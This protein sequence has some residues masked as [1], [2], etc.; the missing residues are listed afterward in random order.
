[1]KEILVTGG[2]GYIGSHFV[3]ALRGKSYHPVIFDNLSTGNRKA[4]ADSELIVGELG[5]KSKLEQ[6]F[7]SRNF[8]AVVHF[9]GSCYVGESVANPRLY[10]EN[11]VMNGWN[12][13]NAMIRS[14]VRNIIF[15]SSCA[16]YGV[17]QNIPITEKEELKPLSPYGNSKMIFELMLKDYANAY[18]ISATSLRYFNAAGAREE[19]NI[20]E[21]HRPETRLIPL[22]I[23][24]ALGKREQIDI[25]GTD[26]D[27]DD[28]T[29]VRDYIH[30]SDLAYAHLLALEQL[31]EKKK[32]TRHYNL[33]SE[34]GYS[35]LEVI[36]MVRNI[37]GKEIKVVEKERREGDPPLLVAD[38]S[39]IREELDWKAE[40]SSI[41]NIVKTAWKW[42]SSHPDGFKNE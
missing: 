18:G 41:E 13:L 3:Q 9:A 36:D 21:C 15:S 25:F 12:L 10:Y 39:K 38:S 33:G 8:H 30:V 5:D 42:H 7:Q 34:K 14:K 6:L 35:V 20:G 29:C 23:E 27:T 26:Y 17:P 2:A 28:G 1:M 24:V 37:S 40:Q 31:S 32:G 19:G 4:V 22:V 11:N 16:V